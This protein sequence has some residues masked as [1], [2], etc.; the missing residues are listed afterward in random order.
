MALR[1]V[2]LEPLFVPRIWGAKTLAPLFPAKNSLTEPIGEVWLTGNDCRFADGPFAGERLA[3]S[4]PR[5]SSDWASTAA[6]RNRPFP[7]LAKFLFPEDKLSVQVHPND[8]YVRRHETASGGSGKTEMWYVVSARPGAEVRAGLKPSVDADEFRRAIVDN[9]AEGLIQRIPVQSG[10][11]ILVPAGTVHTIGPG[12]VLCEIQQNSDLTYRVFDFHRLGPDGRPRELH[13]EKAF[14]VIR[15]GEQGGG[16]ILSVALPQ[17]GAGSSRLVECAYF[18]VT[19]Y[20]FEGAGRIPS[21]GKLGILVILEGSGT[22]QMDCGGVSL[23]YS[24][25]QAWV[26]PCSTREISIR[27]Q[28]PTTILRATAPVL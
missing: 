12:M 13:I 22:M 6:A 2:R 8:D 20:E 26:V 10:D 28:A 15:F 17:E 3:D 27:A 1:P 18:S 24:R 11:T 19:R 5:M 23:E 4:W 25:A 7:L 16:K 14:D 9:T 21:D